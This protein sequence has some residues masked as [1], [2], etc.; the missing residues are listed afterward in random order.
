[1]DWMSRMS[2]RAEL[3]GRMLDTL[4]VNTHKLTAKSDKEEVR[5]AVERCRSCEHSIDCHAWLEAHKD[6]ASAPMPTCPN[7]GVFKNWADRM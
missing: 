4:G 7:A 2:E 6:G 3:M 5:L 1:M